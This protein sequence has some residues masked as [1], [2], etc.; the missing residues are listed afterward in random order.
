MMRLSFTTT[1]IEVLHRGLKL[2]KSGE[3]DDDRT[4]LVVVE[5]D[6]R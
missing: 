3:G 1:E 4:I 2:R 5:V 6:Q